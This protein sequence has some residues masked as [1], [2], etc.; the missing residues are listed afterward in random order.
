MWGNFGLLIDTR[1]ILFSEVVGT[2]SM[3]LGT[4]FQDLDLIHNF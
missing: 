2:P 3:E 4:V 1:K